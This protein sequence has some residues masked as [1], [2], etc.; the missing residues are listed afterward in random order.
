[1]GR[2]LPFWKRAARSERRA[3]KL[4][5][6]AIASSPYRR[7]LVMEPLECR[8]LLTNV[9]GVIASSTTWFATNSPYV[10][11]SSVYV[12]N[13]ATLT[14]QGNVTVQGGGLYIDDDGSGGGSRPVP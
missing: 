4:R 10:I 7:H 14:I 1:M 6:S 3:A 5:Q 2:G 11:T 9:S 12:E 8:H 13:G